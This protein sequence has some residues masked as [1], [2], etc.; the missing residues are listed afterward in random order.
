V[1]L[2]AVGPQA[3]KP[4]VA[5]DIKVTIKN[6]LDNV[7]F[8]D[9]IIKLS[10]AVSYIWKYYLFFNFMYLN[11]LPRIFS[12]VKAAERQFQSVSNGQP[13]PILTGHFL[14]I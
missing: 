9:F 5:I 11:I 14:Y 10:S 6:I 3:D 2:L 1:V 13:N 12:I 4:S 7:K 8:F